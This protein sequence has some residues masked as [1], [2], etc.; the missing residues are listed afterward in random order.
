MISYIIEKISKDLFDV[1]ITIR[2]VDIG[3]RSLDIN[4][5]ARL[6][7]AV[8]DFDDALEEILEESNYYE[9]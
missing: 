6:E 9:D 3:L 2:G 4:D 5:L 8:R 7:G 1:Y